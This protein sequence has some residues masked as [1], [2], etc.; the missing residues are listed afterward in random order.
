MDISGV[1]GRG[2]CRSGGISGE[3]VVGTGTIQGV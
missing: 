3:E 1:E 2:G